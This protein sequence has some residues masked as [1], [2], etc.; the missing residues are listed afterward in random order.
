MADK[1]KRPAGNGARHRSGGDGDTDLIAIVAAACD[2]RACHCTPDV[3][4][5]QHGRVS[6]AQ[7]AHAPGCP[8]V[9]G[10]VWS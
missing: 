8:A 9:G 7:V 10:E 1:R 6:F 5:V 3:K 4:I 2:V